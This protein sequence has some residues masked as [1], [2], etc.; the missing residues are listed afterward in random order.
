MKVS[1]LSTWIYLVLVFLSGALL[2]AF[3]HRLYTANSVSAAPRNAEEYRRN[4]I[5][6]MRTRLK[7]TDEQLSQ[8]QPILD[9][10]RQRFHAFHERTKPELKA[11]QDDQVAKVRSILSE[12]QRA[13]YE[14]MREERRLRRER[15][16]A[17]HPGC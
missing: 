16:K 4:Y 9:G 12:P 7:L 8:L 14:K 13:E 1:K 17:S 5:Q 11:I 3:S 10:T 2:G 15:K 6:E